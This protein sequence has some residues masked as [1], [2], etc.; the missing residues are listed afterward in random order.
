[1]AVRK[2]ALVA[3]AFHPELTADVRYWVAIELRSCGDNRS[4]VQCKQVLSDMS[5]C[6]GV[7]YKGSEY[8]ACKEKK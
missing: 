2:G 6:G 7:S 3:T 4:A 5:H 1:M 8:G